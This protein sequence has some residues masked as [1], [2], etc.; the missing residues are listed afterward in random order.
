MTVAAECRPM[1]T[2]T[3]AGCG[4]IDSHC[5]LQ[6]TYRPEESTPCERCAEA[7]AAGVAGLVCVGTDADTSR[8]AVAL[9]GE[10]RRRPR[11]GRREPAPVR[12]T[13]GP[14]PPSGSIPMTPRTASGRSRRC[15]AT[16]WPGQPR[17]GGGGGGVRSRLPLRPFAAS[18]P[19]GDVRRPGRPGPPLRADPGRAHP[20]GVGRHPR[21]PARRRPPRAHRAA[22][23]HRRTRRGAVAVSTSARFCRSAGSSPSRAPTTCGPPPRCARLDRLL[24]E[25]DAPF[26]APV[27]HRGEKNRPAWVVAVGEASPRSRVWHAAVA[28]PTMRLHCSPH[29]RRAFARCLETR[30]S[31]QVRCARIRCGR[32]RCARV[33][34]ISGPKTGFSTGNED[35][36]V[37]ER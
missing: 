5:H 37:T 20:R 9:V 10:V 30:T 8:Q 15:C 32:E 14:G 4:W 31:A 35:S 11:F 27:P 24:V 19:A 2:P 6:D 3:G 28:L 29:D 34:T 21:H 33:T 22:L 17:R 12:G 36:F 18:G 13:S 25:T 7:A 16:P 26:L 1:G 23:L